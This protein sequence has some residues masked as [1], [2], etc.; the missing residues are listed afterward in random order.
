MRT[1]L[2]KQLLEGAQTLR[3]PHR[4]STPLW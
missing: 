3:E 4:P 1:V 2:K